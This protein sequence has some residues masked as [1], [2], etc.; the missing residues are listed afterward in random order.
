MKPVL[1]QPYESMK[2]N[3]ISV[4]ILPLLVL[5]ITG[6]T[7]CKKS[8]EIN[9]TPVEQPKPKTTDLTGG[10]LVF[11]NGF[12][13][14]TR[15]VSTPGREWRD[16]I[17]GNDGAN[18]LKSD[19][20]NDLR[21]G[22]QHF[23]FL[24]FNYEQGTKA[25][26]SAEIVADPADPTSNNKVLRF[27]ISE[28]NVY[29]R[30]GAGNVTEIK[31]RVQ[32]ELHNNRTAPAGGYMKEYYQKV[33]MYLTPDFSALVNSV[34]PE[35]FGW[36][37][38]MEFRNNP[39]WDNVKGHE[40]RIS[41]RVIKNTPQ[42]YGDKLRFSVDAQTL[43]SSGWKQPANWE[44]KNSTFEIPFGKW[45]TIELYMKEGDANNGRFV[46][47]ATVDNAKTVIVDK[48]GLMQ[49]DDPGY[50]PDGF[51]DWSPMKLYCSKGVVDAFSTQGKTLDVY[52]D[53]LELWKDRRP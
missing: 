33:R 44:V 1:L 48:T 32:A 49:D 24:Y 7:S 8:E 29:L 4:F 16:D 26:R 5:A 28:P 34:Y 3:K 53:D 12:Q 52:W 36:L 43:E 47:T 22:S 18:V 6:T 10:E 15:I 2:K 38:L 13:G 35:K 42:K 20:V 31:G 21:N 25:Q 27:R 23:N 39:S 19:W 51:N 50:V 46:M 11:Q 30:D 37:S 41:V 45:M 9:T 14:T 17:E 40:F